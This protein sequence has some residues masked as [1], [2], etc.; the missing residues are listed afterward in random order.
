M[1]IDFHTHVFPDQLA[2]KAMAELSACFGPSYTPAHDGTVAG[3]IKSMDGAN[4]DISVIQPVVTKPSRFKKINKWVQN[5]CFDP[6]PHSNRIVGFGGIYPHTDT[7]KEDINFIIELGLK[8]L[9][10]HAEYQDFILDEPKML[11]I[12]DYA[13]SQGL[14]ILHHAGFDPDF[15]PPFKSS[16]QQFANVSNA[17][18][19]GIMIAAHFGGWGQWD[20]VE[21]HLVGSN[22]YLDTSMGFEFFPQEQ[23]VRIVRTHG[24]DKIL[25]ATDSPWSHACTEIERLR[26]LPLSSHE[27]EAILGGN[28]KRILN[29]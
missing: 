15:P 29:I 24:I 20:E 6:S 7:Y 2:P 14:I 1:I 22:I 12:Y 10:F 5:L 18:K 9:K 4:V 23:F 27:K 16:P 25:F 8:G 28:A 19:G 3:L 11:P 17:M 13:L 26:A 21:H